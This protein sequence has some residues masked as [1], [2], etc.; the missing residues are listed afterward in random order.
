MPHGRVY[1]RFSGLAPKEA[2]AFFD[3]EMV[4]DPLNRLSTLS[5]EEPT[6]LYDEGRSARY[7][8]LVFAET[9]LVSPAGFMALDFEIPEP[10]APWGADDPS[11]IVIA[12]PKTMYIRRKYRGV[13]YGL[14][15]SHYACQ[16]ICQQ[17]EWVAR[18]WVGGRLR[19]ECIVVADFESR[20]GE[21][22]FWTIFKGVEEW[23]KRSRRKIQK[24]T[25]VELAMPED[26]AGY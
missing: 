24:E 20:S 9:D 10:D 17:L 18:R 11:V 13:G 8:P 1:P 26:D 6:G 14:M 7:R 12:E 23:V 5:L 2:A 15:L 4:A 22:T 25:N 19:L 21:R 3:V 16:A